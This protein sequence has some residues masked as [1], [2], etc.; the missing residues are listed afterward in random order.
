MNMQVSLQHYV[1]KHLKEMHLKP[2]SAPIK[3][4]SID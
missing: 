2:L 1:R 4:V 3:V